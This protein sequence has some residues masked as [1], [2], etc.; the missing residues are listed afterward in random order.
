MV[1]RLRHG[2]AIILGKQNLHEF[3]YGGSSMISY[4]GEVHNPWDTARIAGGSSGGSAASVAA[5]LGYAAVGTDTAGSVRLP[6]SYCGV[7]GLKP[8]FGR[9]SVRGVIP[10]ASSF[11]HVGPITN[12]VCDA[13]LML[14][15]LAGHNPDDATTADVPIID[16]TCDLDESVPPLRI[17]IPRAFFFDDLDADVAMAVEKAIAVF[18]EMGCEIRD[19]IQLEVS[20]DRT[21]ASAES[22]AYHK[23]FV[24][25]SPE[26]Y[27]P[28]TLARIKSGENIA[29][30]D[31][32]R[33]KRELAAMR[34]AILKVFDEVDVLLTPTV[35][36]PP[37]A[38]AELKQSPDKLRPAE[39]LMLRNTRPFNVWGIP[40]ISLPCGFT[41]DSMPIGLQLAGAPWKPEL[42]HLA[43]AYE[44]A[45]DWH[46]KTPAL[47]K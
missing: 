44:Q 6:A 29:E 37:P 25:R 33:A 8:T 35:P 40:A 17:G 27:Q 32:E 16:Y 14:Q 36:I 45:T 20:T 31:V 21:L 41:K 19:E 11:D 22:Y 2:G 34:E 47:E 28:A 38:I 26:L 23:E 5:G 15:V 3:A 46:R 12:C 1:R 7:V 30:A 24:A 42:L 13:G 4:F 10:L 18:R 9:V 43:N 39:L